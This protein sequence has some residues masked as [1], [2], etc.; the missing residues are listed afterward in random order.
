MLTGG[1]NAYLALGAVVHACKPPLF[2]MFASPLLGWRPGLGEPPHMAADAERGS[3]LPGALPVSEGTVHMDWQAPA[4]PNSSFPVL[5]P[6][7]TTM[8]GAPVTDYPTRS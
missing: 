6:C 3:V 2:V 4:T 8:P 7:C 5:G 1:T